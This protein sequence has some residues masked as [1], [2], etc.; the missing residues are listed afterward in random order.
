MFANDIV[1]VNSEDNNSEK[2]K[3]TVEIDLQNTYL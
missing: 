2:L 3:Q 1:L